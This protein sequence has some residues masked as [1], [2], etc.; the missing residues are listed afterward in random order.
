MKRRVFLSAL[1]FLPVL[2]WAEERISPA[3]AFTAAVENLANIYAPTAGA[4]PRTFSTTLKITRASV[5]ELAN[6][7]ANVAYQAP[8]KMMLSAEVQDQR[9]AVGRRGDEIWFHVPGK[10]WA[11]IGRPDVPKFLRDPQSID[12]TPVPPFTFPQKAKIAL[13]PTASRRS[14][15]RG[16]CHPSRR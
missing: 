14:A 3:D 13:L 5:K 10:N 1:L 7:A 11:V 16:S 6:R 15:T 4:E 2:T 8:D 9:Y 12:S